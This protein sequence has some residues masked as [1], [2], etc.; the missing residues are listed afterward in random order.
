[1]KSNKKYFHTIRNSNV[2]KK[3][4]GS[5][6]EYSGFV[7]WKLS[8]N[9]ISSRKRLIGYK[10]IHKGEKCFVIGNGPSLKQTDLSLLQNN[11][12]FGSNRIYLI[13]EERNFAPTYYVSVNKLV[14]EQCFMDIN[15]LQMPKFISWEPRKRIKFDQ[16]TIFLR[17]LAGTGFSKNISNGI[18]QGSTVT[19]VAMQ[20]AYFMGFSQV[21]L[22]GV[23]HN[24][25][26]KGEPHKVVTS[27]GED[28]DHFSPQ[29]FGKGFRWQLPDL[30]GSE[31]AYLLAK[32]YFEQDNREIKDATIGGKLQV[33]SKVNYYSLFDK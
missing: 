25:S 31:H 2:W 32:Q 5:I 7:N 16:N 29:Y 1:M 22:I 14:I 8:I 20:I 11:I 30:K 26:T 15:N 10:N 33:F 13:T 18:W 21:I 3:Y 28:K 24:F 23:D 6:T 17:S 12:T 4:T 19:Y 9:G 27:Q